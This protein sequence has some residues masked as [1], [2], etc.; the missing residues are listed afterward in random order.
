MYSLQGGPQ[1]DCEFRPLSGTSIL[2]TPHISCVFYISIFNLST[3]AYHVNFRYRD[4]LLGTLIGAG[5][6]RQCLLAS[7]LRN[8]WNVG[9]FGTW[10]CGYQTL[11]LSETI[12]GAVIFFPV[13]LS[14]P[15]KICLLLSIYVYIYIYVYR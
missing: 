11:V 7:S 6:N 1:P 3:L 4:I 9:N 2:Q 15:K 13:N 8:T 12:F 10:T 14:G 5:K